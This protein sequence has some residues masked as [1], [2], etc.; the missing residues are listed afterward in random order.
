MAWTPSSMP[1]LGTAAS[2]FSLLDPVSGDSRSLLQLRADKATVV[3]FLSNRSPCVRHIREALVKLA[4][5][6]RARGVAFVAISSGDG[7]TYPEDGPEQMRA[8]A[9]RHGFPFPYLHDESQD[10]ARAYGATCTPDFFVYDR[11]LRLAYRGRFDE[12]R[13]DNRVPVTGRDLRA[14]INALVAGRPVEAEQQPSLGCPIQ[15]Q[16]YQRPPGART[17]GFLSS[18]MEPW[19]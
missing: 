2:D 8:I 17:L 7:E 10:V 4:H 15:W 11:H 14:A 12:A 5:D 9:L 1:A 3:M 6:Y 19:R 13:P 16:V 18:T